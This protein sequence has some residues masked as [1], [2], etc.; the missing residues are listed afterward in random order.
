MSNKYTI[1][2]RAEGNEDRVVTA[3][4]TILE[5]A[6]K[7]NVPLDAPCS[8]NGTC[9]KCRVKVL[10]GESESGQ[11]RHISREDYAQ[12]YR[13]ACACEIR[14]DMVIFVPPSALAYQNRIK[15][16]GGEREQAVFS[17]LREEL[18]TLGFTGDSGLEIL[19]LTL[20]RP[21]LGNP[22]ADRERLLM[23][24]ETLRGEGAP[25][26]GLSLHAQRK[27]PA[28]LREG[29]FSVTCVLRRGAG[30]DLVLNVFPRGASNPVI[31]GLAIDIGTTSVSILLLDLLSGEPLALGS[32]GNG[33]IRYGADVISRII[34][35]SRPGGLERLQRAV[36]DEC[37]DP[38][39]RA[40]C[41]KGGI[42]SEDIYRAAVA[43][44]TTMTHLFLG[45]NPAY[46]RLEPYVPAF[47][48]GGTLRGID[49]GLFL[50]PDAEVIPAPGI[51]SYVGG[52]ITA[53]TFSSGVYKKEA[54]SLLIDLGTNGE[55]VFG[56]ADFL[57][58]CACSA[59]PAFEGG[60][61]SCGMRATDGAV[62]ACGIDRETMEPALRIIG[63][64]GQKPAGLCGSG[65]IDLI[66]E[67]F[68]CGII[69]ARGKFIREGK[70]VC[71]DE[72]GMAG[73]TI[74]FAGETE[75]G[76][77]LALT[78][79]D[80]DNFIRAKGAIFSAI[81]TMLVSLDF[82]VDSI[83][84]VYI[85]GGIGSG[86]NV[87]NAIRIGMFPKLPL[88]RYHYIG[89]S[90]LSGAYAMVNSRR[91]AG[92][93]TEISRGMTYLELSSHPGYMDEFVAAC[94][95]PHTDGGLFE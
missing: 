36:I 28:A 24:L 72:W 46:L 76:R 11:T 74:A 23:A 75:T 22:I 80:I 19:G 44:N 95:L 53:G 29:D 81:R 92:K 30:E 64:A 25:P 77:E 7:A 18:R 17:A 85:A 47:F 69:N 15:I 83:E 20:S 86:I 55:L 37:I 32:A 66:G 39:I 78:E 88:E 50:H 56:N 21:D 62:E 4:E 89:N 67:L 52:D 34:E 16:S 40:L 3:G 58:S 60:D 73:Y 9:G 5:A 65:L 45:V 13:L 71:R 42:D 48:E 6:K 27:L 94:F 2:F 90:S 70:R 84:E 10:S 54:L 8:G 26:L 93:V 1:V 63:A 12:G 91:A 41:R 57:M 51:G 61:I 79:G 68:R 87:E 43:A 14:S 35:S 49:T 38:L 59:G 33:Q 31:A 82:T